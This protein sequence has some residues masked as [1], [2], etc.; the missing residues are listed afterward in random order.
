MLILCSITY[1][2]LSVGRST[3]IVR[4]EDLRFLEIKGRLSS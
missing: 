4:K 3:Y 1:L 2:L